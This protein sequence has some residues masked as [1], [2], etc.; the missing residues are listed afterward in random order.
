MDHLYN[1]AFRVERLQIVNV[2]GGE[3]ETDWV[4]ATDPDPSTNDLLHYLKGR[5]DLNFLRPGKDIPVAPEAG[6]AQDRIGVLFTY[7]YAPIRPG[8]RIIAIENEKGKIPVKGTFE[9]RPKPDEA[10]DYD[11]VHH[12]EIQV[13]EVGQSLAAM[14]WPGED[15]L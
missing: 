15:P 7:P 12:L 3:A 11:D 10:I 14:E 8:D 1:S 2:I 13:V 9:I 5:L 6:K 4:Q